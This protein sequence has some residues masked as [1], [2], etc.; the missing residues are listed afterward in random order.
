VCSGVR[1]YLLVSL[2]GLTRSTGKC[3]P[4]L[5]KFSFKLH[6]LKVC[7]AEGRRA[8]KAP[9]KG[10]TKHRHGLW[11]PVYTYIFCH[12]AAYKFLC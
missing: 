8:G 10:L 4:Q 6:T 3:G 12:Y 5:G 7:P 9:K 1:N 2:R 11:Q